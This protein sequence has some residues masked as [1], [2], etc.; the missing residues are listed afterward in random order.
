MATIAEMEGKMTLFYSKRTGEI[1]C[2]ATGIQDMSFWGKDAEDYS[3]IWDCV[4][5]EKDEYVIRN[6]EKFRVNPTT[7]QLELLANAI[8]S[9]P[10]AQGV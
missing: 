9:Y 3:I 1:K 10:V 8:P 2:C 5:L 7:K 6:R 4:V